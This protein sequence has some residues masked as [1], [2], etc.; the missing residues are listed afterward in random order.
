MAPACD[1][2]PGEQH[3]YTNS[4][5]QILSLPEPTECSGETRQHQQVLKHH[6]LATKHNLWTLQTCGLCYPGVCPAKTGTACKYIRPHLCTVLHCFRMGSTILRADGINAVQSNKLNAVSRLGCY[7][8]QDRYSMH[9]HPIP[10]EH[11]GDN[12]AR[13]EG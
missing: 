3:T 11:S 5:N 6:A 7:A 1:I 13:L 12:T 4:S 2:Q 9:E 10:P 8:Q